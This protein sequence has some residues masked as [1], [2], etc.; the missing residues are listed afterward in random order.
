MDFVR[1]A[2][3]AAALVNAELDDLDGLVAHLNGRDLLHPQA[4]DRDCTQLRRFQREL[5]PAFEAGA[6]GD[7]RRTVEELN[8]LLVRHPISPQV[9]DHDPER[10]HLH[11][12]ARGASVS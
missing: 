3:G 1:Y 4:T 12:A 7:V 8:G 9:S 10:L 2:E 5:R 6:A 11:V